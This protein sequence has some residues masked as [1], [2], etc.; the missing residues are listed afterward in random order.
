MEKNQILLID[1]DTPFCRIIARYKS[2]FEI[3]NGVFSPIERLKKVKGIENVLY[4]HP[5]PVLEKIFSRKNQWRSFREAYP[6]I[7]NEIKRKGNIREIYHYLKE[8]FE[9]VE[10]YSS[11][12]FDIF[13]SLDSVLKNLQE[14]LRFL[15]RENYVSSHSYIQIIGNPSDVWIHPSVEAT[16]GV[17]LDARKGPIVIE[18][19][20]KITAFTYIE[21]PF[22]A[23][24]GCHIDNARITG[25]V[26][27]GT[28]CRVGGEI[29]NSIFGNFSN[30]HHEG[31]VGHSIIGDWVN[32]GALTTTSDLKNNYG[33]VKLYV[34][35]SRLPDLRD[36]PILF[37]TN[38]LK[39]GSIIG[40]C[41][42]TSIGTMLNTGTI[43]DIGSNVFGGSPP[44]YLPPFSWGIRG[45]RYELERFLKD[46][47][48]IFARRNQTMS[49]HFIEL[50]R[51]YHSKMI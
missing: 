2:I 8:I 27:L 33:E 26:I 28:S 39:F 23:A 49:S 10:I 12:D 34:P 25:G 48:K 11:Q 42:K 24:E 15:K 21:G 41:V 4:F 46:H 3:R 45:H 43:L 47:E 44:P 9:G 38:R 5:E 40:D 30:K 51:I 14:D 19:D 32:L 31:F 29:E 35:Q 20:T 22:Y 6:E 37:N 50:T 16:F 13:R 18:K 36:T 7:S 1:F 17:V